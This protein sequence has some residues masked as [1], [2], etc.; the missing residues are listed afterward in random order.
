MSN[1]TS[2]LAVAGP[3]A[4]KL[5]AWGVGIAASSLALPIVVSWSK[6][7]L[8][9][10]VPVKSATLTVDGLTQRNVWL[11]VSAGTRFTLAPDRTLVLIENI[12]GQKQT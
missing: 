10:F 8:D 2:M 9:W 6:R 12:T 3:K 11:F 1:L 4:F 5:A 7:H